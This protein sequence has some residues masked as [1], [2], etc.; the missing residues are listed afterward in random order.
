VV[1]RVRRTAPITEEGQMPDTI[2]DIRRLIESRLVEIA[3]EATVSGGRE[4]V[5][6]TRRDGG[7][8]AGERVEMLHRSLFTGSLIGRH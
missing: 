7:P 6:D 2:E 5:E 4:V 1:G 3:D 8:L